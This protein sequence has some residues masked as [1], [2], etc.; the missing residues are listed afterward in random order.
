MVWGRG[1]ARFIL[2]THTMLPRQTILDPELKR[3]CLHIS[4]FFFATMG[5]GMAADLA[6]STRFAPRWRGLGLGYC[7]AY[8]VGLARCGPRRLIDGG[9]EE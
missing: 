8:M 3:R 5:L 9:R 7:V 1:S 4:L 6:A 2:L